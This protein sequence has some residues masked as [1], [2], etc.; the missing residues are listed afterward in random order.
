MLRVKKML[1]SFFH[2]LFYHTEL[3]KVIKKSSQLLRI[4]LTHKQRVFS[5]R[6]PRVRHL[7][8]FPPFTTKIIFR[9]P[10]AKM[11]PL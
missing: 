9:N 4:F 5:L 10:R 3:L 8:K 11:Y 2:H 6:N 7:V 1:F